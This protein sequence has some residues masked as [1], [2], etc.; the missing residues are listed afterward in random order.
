MISSDCAKALGC[1][2]PATADHRLH[3]GQQLV[4]LN[5]RPCY[6]MD[7]NPDRDTDRRE[8]RSIA[9]REANQTASRAGLSLPFPNPWDELDTTKL[10]RDASAQQ[11]HERVRRLSEICRKPPCQRHTL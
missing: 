10:P 6:A 8:L 1:M 5:T 7:M 2:G 11:I 3:R 4:R 9:Q